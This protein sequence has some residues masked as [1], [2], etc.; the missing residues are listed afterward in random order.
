MSFLLANLLSLPTRF[1]KAISESPEAPRVYEPTV[2]DVVSVKTFFFKKYAL[3]IELLDAIIDFA[4]YW[5]HTT[6]KLTQQTS[7]RSGSRE[8]QMLVGYSAHL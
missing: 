4:E 2:E 8:D 5:P 7:I 1:L 3:P 6:T